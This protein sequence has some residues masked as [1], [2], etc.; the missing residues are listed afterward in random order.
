MELFYPPKKVDDSV[1]DVSETIGYYDFIRTQITHTTGKQSSKTRSKQI[2]K[3][4][5]LLPQEIVDLRDV[6]HKGLALKQIVL[7]EFTR[8]F[9]ADKIVSFDEK[10][11]VSLHHAKKLLLKMSRLFPYISHRIEVVRQLQLQQAV[12]NTH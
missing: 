5:V 12:E 6:K 11:K 2:E 7:S 1:K 4:A 8:P 3:R 10:R 9:I